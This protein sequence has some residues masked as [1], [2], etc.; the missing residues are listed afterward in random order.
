MSSARVT[1]AVVVVVTGAVKMSP[2]AAANSRGIR[3]RTRPA[4]AEWVLLCC[5]YLPS[6]SFGPTAPTALESHE[7]VSCPVDLEYILVI[8][9]IAGTVYNL[10][11]I[12]FIE[13]KMCSLYGLQ[14]SIVLCMQISQSCYCQNTNVIR[15]IRAQWLSN[16]SPV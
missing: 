3:N 9:N 16:L 11:N 10:T 7:L 4:T 5:C 15:K 8:L 14:F 6:T 13:D 12:H 2:T 1:I